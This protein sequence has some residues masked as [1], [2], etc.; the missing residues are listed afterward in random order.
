[1]AVKEREKGE[2]TANFML[3]L[4][5][6]DMFS[7]SESTVKTTLTVS[8]KYDVGNNKRIQFQLWNPFMLGK[9]KN[10]N[11]NDLISQPTIKTIQKQN[12][13]KKL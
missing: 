11:A 3:M 6:C 5:K 2:K 4:L 12:E 13:K 10:I 7:N 8:R 1:M 9:S